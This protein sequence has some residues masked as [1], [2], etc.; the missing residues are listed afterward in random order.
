MLNVTRH[1]SIDE[2]IDLVDG[3]RT[4]SSAPHLDRCEVCTRRVTELKAA[5]SAAA[6]FD[7]PDP[8]PLFWGHLSQRIREA[9]L[10][11]GAP[12]TGSWLGPWTR[13]VFP[14]GAGAG[15]AV[16]LA[17]LIAV[18]GGSPPSPGSISAPPP[19]SISTSTGQAAEVLSSDPSLTLVADLTEDMDWETARDAGLASD[20]SAEH[21]V[22]HLSEDELRQL[23]RL[24]QIELG[25]PSA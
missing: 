25:R 6:T 3:T 11:E 20:G 5:M 23:Q 4:R 13:I 2:L 21:A 16:L 10:E 15:V 22:T 1:L 19:P 8:S 24:L 17:V 9:V 18:R 14:L 7:V 12:G